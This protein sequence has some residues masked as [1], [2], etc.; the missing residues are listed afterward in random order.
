MDLEKMAK[1]VWKG[2]WGV[3]VYG[4]RLEAQPKWPW[5]QATAE[6]F[7]DGLNKILSTVESKTAARC[8]EICRDEGK[9]STR[10]MAAAIKAVRFT[11]R[12]PAIVFLVVATLMFIEGLMWM[13]QQA[14]EETYNKGNREFLARSDNFPSDT[15]YMIFWHKG[16][17]YVLDGD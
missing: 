10:A 8:A 12:L 7:A 14:N 15:T 4:Q 3:E 5:T 17:P 13:R 6:L 2:V 1:P 9:E 16:K 11:W